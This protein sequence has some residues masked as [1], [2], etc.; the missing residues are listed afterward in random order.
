VSEM[1]RY[2]LHDR[3][4]CTTPKT[5]TTQLPSRQRVFYPL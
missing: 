3:A 1:L 5:L 2:A 4:L